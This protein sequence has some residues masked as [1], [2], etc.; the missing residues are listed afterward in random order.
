MFPALV[1]VQPEIDLNKWPP[2][3]PLRLSNQMQACFMRCAIAFPCV[4]WNTRANDVFPRGGAAAVP[5]N[6][7][8]Q[9][10][11]FSL[12]RVAAVLTGV[13]VP[14][15]N[16]VASEFH[17]FLRKPVEKYQENDLGNADAK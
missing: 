10:E 3:G 12:E 6:H 13:L 7:V 15:E 8:V 14:L 11:V 1:A 5:W 2:F 16:I 9:I 17:L 4:A